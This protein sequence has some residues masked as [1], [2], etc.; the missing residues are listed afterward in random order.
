MVT[1]SI[2]EFGNTPFRR[3]MKNIK[4]LLSFFGSSSGMFF[5]GFSIFAVLCTA[6][7]IP[8]AMP[9]I[10]SGGCTSGAAIKSG[11]TGIADVPRSFVSSRKWASPAPSFSAFCGPF[12]SPVITK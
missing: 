10:A 9:V 12:G 4:D 1:V 8:P 3:L 2:L 11:L 6:V 5:P 7:D